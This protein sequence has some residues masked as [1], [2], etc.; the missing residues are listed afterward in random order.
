MRVEKI[1]QYIR[2]FK[3]ITLIIFFCLAAWLGFQLSFDNTMNIPV[4]P[5]AGVG[6]ALLIILGRDAWPGIAIGA[7]ITQVFSNWN[8]IY[9]TAQDM[10]ILGVIV[11]IGA[12]LQAIAG[13][14]L[15]KRFIF[16]QGNPFSKAKDSFSFLF[17]AFAVSLISAITTTTALI[18]PGVISFESAPQFAFS[19]WI[20]NSVGIV[21]FTPLILTIT[22]K[23]KITITR[24]KILEGLLFLACTAGIISLYTFPSLQDTLE[25]AFPFLVIPMLMWLSFRF[26]LTTALSVM[27]IVA[28]VA[29]FR[30]TQEFGPFV[31]PE[32]Y[33]SM[34]LLQAFVGVIAI[35]T[36]IISATV[37]ER[38]V[39]Q[40]ELEVFNEDLESKITKRTKALNEEITTRTKAEEKLTVSNRKLRK[41]NAELD[42]FVYSVS[43]DLRAPIASVL[44]LINLAKKDRSEKRNL[45]YLEMIEDSAIQQDKFIKKILDQSRNSRLEVKKEKIA[46]ENLLEDIFGQLKFLDINHKVSKTININQDH[47]F[48]SDPWRLKVIFNNLLSNSI[49]HKN[50]NPPKIEIDI[51]VENEEAHIIIHDNGKGIPRKHLRHVFKMFYRATDQNAGSGLGLYIVKEAVDKLNGSIKLNSKEGE[52]TEVDLIIPSLN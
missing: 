3:I 7:L 46:F 52:G 14:F 16:T 44:G 41:T 40:K 42:N 10:I 32:T 31:V 12:T 43:H 18:L 35:S 17:I 24:E 48:Y 39:I 26:N 28:L 50:G 37:Q 29:I 51:N 30:T 20:S 25:K 45:Q 2:D 4:W 8:N 47:P 33:N 36:L 49:R 11:S 15:Y 9:L 23:I 21:L 27:V 5:A 6:L 1:Q 38:N 34:L 22:G 13:N 19:W